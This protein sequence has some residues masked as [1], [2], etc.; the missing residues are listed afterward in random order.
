MKDE[1]TIAG[2]F[3]WTSPVLARFL[4]TKDGRCKTPDVINPLR[5]TW[6][7][8]AWRRIAGDG[9]IS[10]PL[11]RD[12]RGQLIYADNGRMAVQIAAADRGELATG[13]PLGGEE[14][15]RA[16]AYS[17]YLAYFGTYTLH[18]GSVIHDIDASLFPNWSGEKQTRPFS[19]TPDELVLAT[20]PMQLADGTTVVNELSWAREGHAGK[21]Q[22]EA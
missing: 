19:L 14:S 9:A 3:V 7:L 20:P 11:G 4:D 10:Y 17:G 15:A 18:G 22:H 2:S 1:R 21:R 16:A 5:G 12:A 13:D 6:G 8:I